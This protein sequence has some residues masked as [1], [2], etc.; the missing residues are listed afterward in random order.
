MAYDCAGSI[1]RDAL[2]QMHVKGYQKMKS[3]EARSVFRALQARG[4]N[5]N[6]AQ[7]TAIRGGSDAVMNIL[8]KVRVGV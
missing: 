6:M 2:K 5:E 8:N 3:N 7:D 4:N 1:Y